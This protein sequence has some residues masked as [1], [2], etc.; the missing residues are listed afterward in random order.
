MTMSASV[1][2]L[3]DRTKKVKKSYTSSE[4]ITNCLASL[5]AGVDGA[6]VGGQAAASQAS[7]PGPAP[8]RPVPP[9]SAPALF[10]VDDDGGA[11]HEALPVV[12]AAQQVAVIH[13]HHHRQDVA[14]V[15]AEVSV[16]RGQAVVE[17]LNQLGGVSGR[18]ASAV[19]G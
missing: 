8:P 3:R 18:H 6:K 1:F 19:A 9:R 2:S 7:H 14:S 17:R 15:E 5:D 4:M 16:V 11:R 12:V 13:L 10:L